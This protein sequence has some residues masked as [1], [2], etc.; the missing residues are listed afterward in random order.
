MSR[1]API[2]CAAPEIAQDFQG[3]L[4]RHGT[5][6]DKHCPIHDKSLRWERNKMRVSGGKIEI[7]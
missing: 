6:R 3:M 4:A 1:P 2:R 5:D 7:S